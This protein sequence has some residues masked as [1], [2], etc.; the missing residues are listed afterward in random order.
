MRG[1]Q[2][3]FS[4]R[5]KWGTQNGK[6][7][8]RGSATGRCFLWPVAFIG[9]EFLEFR[10]VVQVIEIGSFAAQSRFTYPAAKAFLKHP[11]A[12][13]FFSSRQ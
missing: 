8:R 10:V 11:I 1:R 6:I 2:P 3:Y 5:E 12:A 9:N 7:D 13:T 4:P